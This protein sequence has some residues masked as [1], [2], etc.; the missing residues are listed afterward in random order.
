MRERANRCAASLEDEG[1]AAAE[2]AGRW[3]QHDAAAV[4]HAQGQIALRQHVAHIGGGFH[5]FGETGYGLTDENVEAGHG[6]EG[7]GT[8]KVAGQGPA[9]LG[10]P[11]VAGDD[12]RA[13]G[14]KG[15]GDPGSGGLAASGPNHGAQLIRVV[16][17]QFMTV[18]G[19]HSDAA[20]QHG[21]ADMLDRKSTR[22]NS[23][24]ANI[25]Y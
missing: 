25:S 14:R 20:V 8:V 1:Q 13:A 23:S 5:T 22:L 2:A 17:E 7:L 3:R 6:V 11:L 4:D 24:H 10:S 15:S 18:R 21:G 19:E 9:A 12:M 16:T